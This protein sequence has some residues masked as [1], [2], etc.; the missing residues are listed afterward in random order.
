[1][2][3]LSTRFANGLIFRCD[4]ERFQDDSW[5]SGLVKC[6]AV[7]E[8]WAVGSVGESS[9]LCF[10]CYMCVPLQ[11]QMFSGKM[12]EFRGEVRLKIGEWIE[13][14]RNNEVWNLKPWD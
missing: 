2:K 10:V 11:M 6:D 5:A 14:N 1:M 4:K 12:C 8:V 13:T 7:G 3:V 9:S